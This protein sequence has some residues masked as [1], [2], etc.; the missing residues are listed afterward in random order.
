[1]AT[2]DRGNAAEAY[3]IGLAGKKQDPVE[4][5]FVAGWIALTK[6]N[7]ADEALARFTEMATSAKSPAD[8]AASGYWV[9]RAL[10]A[11]GRNEEGRRMWAM[12][13]QYG[14]TFYGQVAAA[15]IGKRPSMATDP[16]ARFTS[17]EATAILSRP[18]GRRA[19]E[20]YHSKKTA[21]R[22]AALIEL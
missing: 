10:A 21:A 9:G 12:A 6:Q 15:A 14:F 16:R 5:N 17:Q 13:S 4:A 11:K 22:N 2:S 8:R 7:N 1:M 3:K 18:E 20:A 19:I